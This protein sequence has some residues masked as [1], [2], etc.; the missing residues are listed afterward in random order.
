MDFHYGLCFGTKAKAR[1]YVENVLNPI[2]P[3]MEMLTDAVLD[4]LKTDFTTTIP[5]ST[6]AKVGP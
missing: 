1:E 5:R 2:S 4:A 6:A 3:E